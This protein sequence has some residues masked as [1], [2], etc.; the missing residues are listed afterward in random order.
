MLAGYITF[1]FGKPL[2][3]GHGEPPDQEALR[4]PRLGP[5]NLE[6]LTYAASVAGI[7]LIWLLVQRNQAMLGIL[8]A[9]WAAAISYVGYFW[10]TKCDHIERQRLLLAFVLLLGPIVFFTLFEQA[11][12]SLNLFADR[13]TQ[14]ALVQRADQDQHPWACQLFFGTR[15][16][17]ASAP[18]GALWIDMGFT[19]AQTQAF[20]AGFILIFAPLFAA[21]WTLLGRRR[22]DPNPVTKF[23]LGLVQVG[24]GFL[25]IVWSAGLADSA[26]RLAACRAGIRLPTAHHRR[27]VPKPGG[28]FGDH[29]ALSA[30]PGLD[31]DGGMVPGDFRRRVHRREH[32]PIEQEPRRPEARCSTPPRRPAHLSVHVPG[33]R[34]GGRRPSALASSSPRHSSSTGRTRRRS[35]G[36]STV[37]REAR[38]HEYQTLFHPGGLS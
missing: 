20:N 30:S 35:S 31:D 25:V 7:G 1:V 15:A 4:R 3:D 22:R 10:V 26:F 16:M 2:L 37:M 28:D 23:G 21:L 19:A 14:L 12:T 33:D 24:L 9:G 32:R 18:P 8:G 6:I 13:N 5:L 38:F 27:D 11:A 34:L 17:L 36:R 29:Q